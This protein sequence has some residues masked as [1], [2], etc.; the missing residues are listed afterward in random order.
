MIYTYFQGVQKPDFQIRS[1][2]IKVDAGRDHQTLSSFFPECGRCGFIV[3][4]NAGSTEAPDPY[5]GMAHDDT[6]NRYKPVV[7]KAAWQGKQGMFSVCR[8]S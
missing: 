1:L 6:V 3:L 5:P 2:S 4:P 7:A 8:V